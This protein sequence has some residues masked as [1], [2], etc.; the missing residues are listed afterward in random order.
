MPK[1]VLSHKQ[2]CMIL[3]VYLIG[4]SM[5]FVPEIGFAGKDAWIST[6][7]A[8][9]GGIFLL[10]VW[11]FLQR[12]FPGMSL[13]QYGI[14]L[15]G[16]WIGYPIGIYLVF[17]M[18][19]I[20]TLIIE[21]LVIITSIIMLPN[22]PT[23]VIRASF[24]TV[25]I[26]SCYK[27]IES[28]ARM[29][30]LAIIPLSLLIIILPV[31]QWEAIGVAVLRPVWIINW[32][33]VMV[34]TINSLV[35]PFAEVLIPAML[36]PFVSADKKAGKFYLLSVLL[37]GAMLLIRTLIALMALGPDLTARLTVP[38][39]SLFRLIELGIFLNRV[40][41]LLLGIWYIGLLMK[42]SIT[43]YA[44]TLGLAQIIG[45]KRLENLWLP[46][47]AVTFFVSLSRYPTLADFG[48]FS[49]YVLPFLALPGEL[50]YPPIL[51]IVYW[52]RSKLKPGTVDQFN[53]GHD[54]FS[55]GEIRKKTVQ[56][57][58]IDHS[59]GEGNGD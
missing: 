51:G 4:A 50:L 20:S 31:L 57:P 24:I 52:L 55:K 48:F 37:A 42:L 8:T 15:L 21:D 9:V 23:I 58:N 2:F 25:A 29:C 3:Y 32:K 43:V 13:I 5:I 56:R 18:F 49:F 12:K 59:S 33:G 10:T 1:A 45:V 30:E 6:I 40:E 14:K 22:T 35:F 11:L 17:V 39:V 38:M 53:Q 27:G 28:I 54:K 36:L 41:G 16:P 19:I 44:G 7:L 34:G 47:A 26:Y 46:M